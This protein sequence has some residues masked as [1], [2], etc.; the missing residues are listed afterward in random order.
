MGQRLNPRVLRTLAN[1]RLALAVLLLVAGSLWLNGAARTAA[2]ATIT[3]ADIGGRIAVMEGP[4]Q[5]LG[6][7]AEKAKLA[8]VASYINN[9]LAGFGLTVQKQPV[10]VL[11]ETFPNIIGTLQGTVCPD[12]SFIVGA[13][14]DT[15]SGTPGA[16]D[17][18]SGV[19][20]MLE[21]ARVLSSQSFPASI[22]F[23]AF[24]FEE[25]GMIGSRQMAMEASAEGK[26]VV[27]MLSLEMIGYYT[28]AAGSQTY[29]PG[30]P[31]GY[32]DTG[33]FIGVGGNTA[34]HALL[35]TFVTAAGTAVPG[36]ATESFE[37]PGNG[38][39]FP[40]MRLS[41]HSP[42]WDAGYQALLITDT[43]YF[44]NPN[45]HLP[46]DTLGTLDMSFAADVA[47]AAVAAIVDSVSDAGS[48][49]PF[50][51]TPTDTPLP[52]AT[53][54]PKPTITPTPTKQPAPGD[55]DGDGCSDVTENGPDEAL[56]GQR[57]YKSP[58]DFYDVETI[59]GPGQDGVVD[60]LFDILS[61][62]NHYQPALGGASP[63]DAHYDR[64]PSTGPNPWNMTGPD[65]VIDLL[66]DIL[67]V[68]L[69]GNHDCT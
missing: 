40:D 47:N 18:T 45:Y 31:P 51:V 9:E 23:V 69:Q 60:L 58:W 16:D 49:C 24:S 66:N 21:A 42:F 13:H 22:E 63:Y 41:D 15:A 1:A 53:S 65:G 2:I 30:F 8:E 50:S 54:T 43:A 20:G 38:E 61:V 39:L 57:D 46:S 48:V 32:P 64:G 28:D 19:A 10:T 3:P 52:T 29:P 6:T 36:L 59:S 5:G 17:N 34:S 14:Y 27:G 35:K 7:P 55:T 37:V 44:R 33:N 68:V 67:G 12:S 62:I 56:G 4:R 25:N 26:D 11:G